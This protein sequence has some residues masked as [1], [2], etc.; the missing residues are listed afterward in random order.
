MVSDKDN[1]RGLLLLWRD[2]MDGQQIPENYN[3]DKDF[4][5]RDWYVYVP[6]R[7]LNVLVFF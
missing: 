4:P 6:V 3:Q 7:L 1:Q 2:S 5:S